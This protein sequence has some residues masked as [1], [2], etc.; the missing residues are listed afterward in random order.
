[1]SIL[2]QA[3]PVSGGPWDPDALLCAVLYIAVLC[4]ALLC[5][6]LLF[7][8]VVLYS[9]VLCYAVLSCTDSD[10][11]RW[12]EIVCVGLGLKISL[13]NVLFLSHPASTVS[14]QTLYKHL[15]QFTSAAINISFPEKLLP[16]QIISKMLLK[17]ENLKK[18][19]QM[20]Q[21]QKYVYA[22]DW[23]INIGGLPSPKNGCTF[24]PKIG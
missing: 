5:C 19:N 22:S 2:F 9:D 13:E 7:F 3:R 18:E 20:R 12:V 6:A 10:D 16:S 24:V 17:N 15:K 1:M 4:I 23:I 8:C 11:L 14:L 21:F